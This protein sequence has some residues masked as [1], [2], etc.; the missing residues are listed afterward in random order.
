MF[1]PPETPGSGDRG[2]ELE[3]PS[4]PVPAVHPNQMGLWYFR[5]RLLITHFLKVR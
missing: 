1:P 5:P 2:G 4:L 3:H